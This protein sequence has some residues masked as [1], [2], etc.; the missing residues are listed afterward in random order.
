M[1]IFA[2]VKAN[3]EVPNSLEYLFVIEPTINVVLKNGDVSLSSASV[4]LDSLILIRL[5]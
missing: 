4:S 1:S 5:S 3:I 2:P